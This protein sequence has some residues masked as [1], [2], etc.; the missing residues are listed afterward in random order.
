MSL[1]SDLHTRATPLQGGGVLQENRELRLRVEALE[2]AMREADEA[3]GSAEGVGLVEY[4]RAQSG[5]DAE[6]LVTLEALLT[7][8]GG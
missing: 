2:A 1:Q 6:S 5:D 8:A 3:V 4:V 7:E